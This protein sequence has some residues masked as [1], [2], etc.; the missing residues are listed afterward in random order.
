MKNEET[1]ALRPLW[2][3]TSGAA[4]GAIVTLPVIHTGPSWV[5]W[6]LQLLGAGAFIAALRRGQCAPAALWLLAGIALVGGRGLGT[7]ADDLTLDRRLAD[8]RDL[9]VRAEVVITQGWTDSRWGRRTRVRV[10]HATR[11]GADLNLPRSCPLEVRGA[12]T[13]DLP[14]PGSVVQTLAGVRRSQLGNLLLVVASP[15]V[16]HDTGARRPLPT[17]RGYLARR[18]IAAAGT[19]AG[20]IRSAELAAALSLGRRDLVPAARRDAWRRSG[21]AHLLAVSG[22]HVGLVGAATWF[23]VTMSGAGPRTSRLVVLAV[24]PAYALLAGASPSA[25]RAA[26]MGGIYLAARLLGRAILPMAAVLLAATFLLLARPSLVAEPG[27]QLTV[28]ITA[29]LVRWV[30]PLTEFLPGPRWVTGAV[31]VPLVAQAA[32][33][34]IVGWHFRS[35]IPGAVPANLL[36]L[37][38]LGPTVLVSVFAAFLAPV[39]PAAAAACLSLVSLLA[40]VLRAGS[41]PARALELVTP[42][43]PVAAVVL[44]VAAGWLAL[45]PGRRARMGAATWFSL[46][47]LLAGRWLFPA[48]PPFDTVE[49]LPV[50]D[51]AAISVTAGGST[52]LFDGGR[53]TREAARL[54]ADRGRRRITAV[55]ISHTDEDHIAGIAQV[56]RSFRVDLLVMQAWMYGEPPTVE[57]LRIARRRGVRVA[58][59]ARGSAIGLGSQR[60]EVVWA[61]ALDPPRK[62]N[63]RSL[64][65]RVLLPHGTLLLTS[66]IGLHTERRIAG[67]SRLACEILIIPHHGSRGS[68][69]SLLLDKASPT[70][71]LIPAAP[72]NTH[73][74][75]HREVLARLAAHGIP[76]RYPARDGWCGARFTDGSW[77]A[78]P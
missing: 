12:T 7:R 44:L 74:H 23:L 72:G 33:A 71:A 5:H 36:L 63:E 4:L 29:A 17:L 10:L 73:G 75:P 68:T 48:A 57:L 8:A 18:L 42:S 53:Q 26:L 45:Q 32:A 31:A 77:T 58:L 39:W 51:G 14:Q 41:A 67:L 16:L 19:D 40:Q 46:L 66:D 62:E 13:D 24:L 69:S 34:P 22:L 76:F 20:R 6:S 65:G 43:M 21:L 60:L 52:L 35:L 28:L 2:L 49:L 47:I 61:T 55:V 37:P 3:L 15:R 27:F 64:V 54:L 11:R 9:T 78:F 59:V 25:L 70:I 1:A 50:S 30:P 56:L 38:L